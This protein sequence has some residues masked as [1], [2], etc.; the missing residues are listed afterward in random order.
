L[1]AIPQPPPPFT[2]ALHGNPV[3]ADP[4][5]QRASIRRTVAK[6]REALKIPASHE[7]VRLG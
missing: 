4:D 2:F 5:P 6:Y 1:P 7:R 3:R